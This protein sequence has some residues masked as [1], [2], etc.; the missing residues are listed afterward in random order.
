MSTSAEFAFEMS[1]TRD[2][3]AAE[4]SRDRF[5]RLVKEHGPAVYRLA[6][7]LSPCREDA[8]DLLQETFLR[9]FKGLARFRGDSSPRTWLYRIL[10]NLSRSRR[11]P[12]PA[13]RGA[14]E[15]A[16]PSAGDPARTTARRDLVARLLAAIGRLPRRQREA[17]LLRVRGGLSYGEIAEVMG[18]R[19][20]AVKAHLVQ[21]RRKLL[22]RFGEEVAEWG[23]AVR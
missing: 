5:D 9:A 22:A 4:E 1:P 6:A 12:P 2:R 21:A 8:E 23:I 18:I 3:P 10:L 14:E 7:R 15:Q 20:G 19:K 13:G 11:R 17:I 16:A